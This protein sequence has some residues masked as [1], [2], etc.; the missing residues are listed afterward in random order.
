MF[1]NDFVIIKGDSYV[2]LQNLEAYSV[3]LIVTSPPYNVGMPYDGYDDRQ[4]YKV[5]MQHMENVLTE[6]YRVL[7]RGGRIAINLPSASMQT[8]GSKE[9]F[10]AIDY[11][12]MMRKIGY[13][14]REWIGWQKGSFALRGVTSWGSWCSPSQPYLRDS[15]EYIIVFSKETH[16]REDKKGPND[17][18]PEEF[19]AFT[20]N[21]WFIQPEVKNRK[22]HPAPFPVELP[23]RLLKLYTW[24]GDTVLD[25]FCGIGTVGEACRMLKRNFIGIDISERYCHIARERLSQEV[26]F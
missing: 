23:Y 6:C 24:P 21:C 25:P 8:T 18:T 1:K 11:V 5:Y 13:L 10:V 7:A 17:I 4:N 15:M 3:H 2:E 26:L 14:D 22:L 12:N 16:K 9:A 19:V 20:K